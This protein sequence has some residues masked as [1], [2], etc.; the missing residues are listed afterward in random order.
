MNDRSKTTIITQEMEGE[1]ARWLLFTDLRK[2]QWFFN[3][4]SYKEIESI[5]EGNIGSYIKKVD[6]YSIKPSDRKKICAIT[7]NLRKR[8][9]KI[10]S[11]IAVSV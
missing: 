11:M 8:P 5:N 4:L 6:K 1:I 10:K 3:G 7:R 2:F 9:F